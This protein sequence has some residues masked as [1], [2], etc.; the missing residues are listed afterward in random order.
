MASSIKINSL[1]Y[2]LKIGK[3]KK[4][5]IGDLIV[6]DPQYC[7]WLFA[8]SNVQVDRSVVNA[9]ETHLFYAR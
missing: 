5:R 7:Q 1:L 6:N 9:L 8:Q 3:Y 2:T 4:K